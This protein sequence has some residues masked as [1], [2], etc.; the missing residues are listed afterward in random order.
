MSKVSCRRVHLIYQALNG[1]IQLYFSSAMFK[2]VVT[3]GFEPF[4]GVSRQGQIKRH[5]RPWPYCTNHLWWWDWL[6][7]AFPPYVNTPDMTLSEEPFAR[8]LIKKQH[9][10]YD[11]WVIHW[12]VLYTRQGL[13]AHKAMTVDWV[14]NKISVTCFGQHTTGVKQHS[15]FPTLSTQT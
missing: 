9:Y 2:V 6:L 7:V 11:Q 12:Q 4:T 14:P 1:T 13:K 15:I 8:C 5:L 10:S 3:V